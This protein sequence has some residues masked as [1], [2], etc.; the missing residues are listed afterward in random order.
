[1]DTR[2]FRNRSSR[3]YKCQNKLTKK[4]Y[5]MYKKM[6][7]L[8]GLFIRTPTL[9]MLSIEDDLVKI[10][11]NSLYDILSAGLLN[12]QTGEITYLFYD[13]DDKKFQVWATEAT[14]IILYRTKDDFTDT[15]PV[16]PEDFFTLLKKTKNCSSV[17]LPQSRKRTTKL[18][19][20][21][22][23]KKNVSAPEIEKVLRS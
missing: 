12:K 7:I 22:N 23:W 16:D 17:H 15:I 4:F 10:Q 1:M 13:E 19:N 21:T 5:F 9:A 8:I 6:L 11:A 14:E 3:S 2:S 18:A 20:E